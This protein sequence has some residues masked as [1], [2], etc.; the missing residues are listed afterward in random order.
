M[1]HFLLLLAAFLLCCLPAVSQ[2]QYAAGRVYLPGGDT[3]SGT[4]SSQL[5]A[6]YVK[7][8]SADE[9]VTE[10]QPHQLKG[11]E[12]DGV[13]YITREVP[14]DPFG[15]KTI[16]PLFMQLLAGGKVNLYAFLERNNETFYYAEKE[17]KM[18]R[19]E[20]G[21]KLTTVNKQAYY[22]KDKTYQ[23]FLQQLFS[24]C[25]KPNLH[26][27]EYTRKDLTNAVLTYNR[28]TDAATA[29]ELTKKEKVRVHPGVR[30]GINVYAE[31]DFATRVSPS[32]G[33]FV[34]MPL[35]KANRILSVQVELNYNQYR[36]VTEQ[37]RAHYAIF[38]LTPLAKVTYPKGWVRPFVAGGFA[39]GWGKEKVATLTNRLL[40]E[41]EITQ[42][43][44]IAETGLQVPFG[45]RYA[46]AAARYEKFVNT[47]ETRITS[48]NFSL[49]FAL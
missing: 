2:D 49:G 8:K 12:R 23:V 45:R 29:R 37:L 26:L 21:K 47:P 24:D 36:V 39:I 27:C 5:T 11:F 38:E 25:S 40:A 46:Y 10:Y 6:R 14:T 48:W 32:A 13:V 1:K 19:L 3:L 33:V 18:T 34:N 35:G 41:S 9:K 7:L 42:P 30:G 28:C 43:K 22:T 4:I 44:L 16:E 17:G 15:V 31:D 20:G